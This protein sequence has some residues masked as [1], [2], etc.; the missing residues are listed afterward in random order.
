MLV[1]LLKQFNIPLEVIT[2]GIISDKPYNTYLDYLNNNKDLHEDILY[3]NNII[4]LDE[5]ENI[6]NRINNYIKELKNKNNLLNEILNNIDNYKKSFEE[7]NNKDINYDEYICDQIYGSYH[8][9]DIYYKFIKSYLNDSEFKETEKVEI[10]KLDTTISRL[11]D[12]YFTEFT[13]YDT[14]DKNNNNI[15][16]L[17]ESFILIDIL[18]FNDY[19]ALYEKINDKSEL[20]MYDFLLNTISN[21][22]NEAANKLKNQLKVQYPLTPD[23]E[24]SIEKTEVYYYFID[25]LDKNTRFIIRNNLD[26]NIIIQKIIDTCLWNFYDTFGVFYNIYAS[27]K[28]DFTHIYYNFESSEFESYYLYDDF[29]V[30]NFLNTKIILPYDKKINY[31]QKKIKDELSQIFPVESRLSINSDPNTVELYYRNYVKKKYKNFILKMKKY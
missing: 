28:E 30:D 15:G 27:L 2:D 9:L 25:F 1:D 3:S 22:Y 13:T 11:Y 6:I 19:N 8:E 4:P 21:L 17:R 26:I 20:Y 16:V 10:Y 7:L 12:L 29:V 31:F 23:Q 24:Y 18:A 14:L 5:L